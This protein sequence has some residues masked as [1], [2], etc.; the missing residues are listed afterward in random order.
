MWLLDGSLQFSFYVIAFQRGVE[1]WLVKPLFSVKQPEDEAWSGESEDASCEYVAQ[2]MLWE[3][4]SWITAQDRNDEK[5]SNENVT[6]HSVLVLVVGKP[7]ADQEYGNR[8]EYEE[9]WRVTGREWVGSVEVNTLYQRKRYV[10][11]LE[12]YMRSWRVNHL[13]DDE[14]Q[15]GIDEL[16]NGEDI[17]PACFPEQQ[18]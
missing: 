5:E 16:G 6:P 3:V 18:W 9:C 2:E 10:Q 12:I 15:T 13:F 17:S 11:L 1:P 7:P 14:Y 4:D 8:W